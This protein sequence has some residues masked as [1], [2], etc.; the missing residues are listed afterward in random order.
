[1]GAWQCGVEG[2]SET[3][4]YHCQRKRAKGEESVRL[5]VACLPQSIQPLHISV[6]IENNQT[7]LRPLLFAQSGKTTIKKCPPRWKYSPS[8]TSVH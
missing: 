6:E 8:S 4:Y 2:E 5:M 3:F 7:M 1:M